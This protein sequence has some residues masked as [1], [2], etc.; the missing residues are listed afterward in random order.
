[1]STIDLSTV[2]AHLAGTIIASVL[3]ASPLPATRIL[4]HLANC[5]PLGLVVDASGKRAL[6]DAERYRLQAGGLR[7]CRY[8]H[9]RL[10]TCDGLVAASTSLVWL[11]ARLPYDL[12]CQLDAA[13]E[14][15][16]TIL[17]RA[18]MRREDRRAGPSG[19]TDEATGEM[20]AASSSAVLVV[21]GLRVAIAEEHVLAQFAAVMT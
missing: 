2:K 5:G 6:T 21:G 9:A 8:R 4:E 16:G 15:A 7:R 20:M 18:G 12:A 14:P 13:A 3:A 11:P 10:L 1:M 19:L 17:G